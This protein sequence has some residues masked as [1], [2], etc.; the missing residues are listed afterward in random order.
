MDDDDAGADDD[1]DGDNDDGMQVFSPN[2]V[3]NCS[4]FINVL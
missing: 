4:V 1:D 2:T 3:V